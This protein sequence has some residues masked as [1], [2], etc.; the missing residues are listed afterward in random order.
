MNK[1]KSLHVLLVDDDEDDF[2]L[3]SA[4]F[5]DLKNWSFELEWCPTYEEAIYS[6]KNCKHDLYIF[7][8][9]LGSRSGIDLIKEAVT[10]NCEEPIILLTGKGD[11]KIAVESLR[12]GAADYLV[13]SELEP[14]I[15]ERSLRYS[16]ERT[17]VV[18]ALR[19]SERRY[20]RIFEESKDMLFLS[21]L[22]GKILDF[23][24]ASNNLTGFDD[25]ELRGKVVLD[26]F[27]KS[28]VNSLWRQ[29]EDGADL[30]EQELRF[31]TKEG[32][33][34]IGIL[35]ATTENENDST[36]VQG[37]LRDATNQ[38]QS[39]RERLFS[40]KLA[41]TSRLVRMLAHE[42]R[43]PLTNVNLSAEQLASELEDEDLHFY[44][45]IIK[46]N[47]A[48][49]N[50]LITQLLQSSR[51]GEFALSTGSLHKILDK[52]L[53]SAHDRMKLK[54]IQ[55]EKHYEEKE[56]CIEMNPDM[57]EIAILNLFTNAIE[58]MP[59]GSGVLKITTRI[60]DHEV[61]VLVADNGSGIS[62]ENMEKVFEPYFT[63]KKSGMGIG[64]ASTLNIVQTHGGRIDVQS[65]EGVGTVFT[66]SFPIVQREDV[67]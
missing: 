58:A 42:V 15:L 66:L 7:D 50:D 29:I 33:R 41:V 2:I 22:E 48:R 35:S 49:I 63:D 37:R 56:I 62:E 5:N 9:L 12:L 52:T 18:K 8:Y 13:K 31:V 65:E 25:E 4:C 51:P 40:E 27:D 11:E 64:L 6:L 59:E 60:L 1:E 26:L 24:V 36:Y 32:E 45:D 14:A 67:V 19:Q 34:K 43:N 55:I 17:K 28:E 54:R 21:D 61:Q 3:T 20:R 39:E 30:S 46:R 57:L 53:V 16:L 23:N 38:K 47:C 10:Q 44:T